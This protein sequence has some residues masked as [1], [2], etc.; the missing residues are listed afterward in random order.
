MFCI[1]IDVAQISRKLILNNEELKSLT[2]CRFKKI[3]ELIKL[4]QTV[5]RLANIFLRAGKTGFQATHGIR[6]SISYRF[7]RSET[8]R[9]CLSYH[10][11]SVLLKGH[12][13]RDKVVVIRD[14]A[15]SCSIG[16]NMPAKSL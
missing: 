2:R 6:A 9:I 10:I 14:A 11:K 4:K 7:P 8:K 16:S 5:N 12:Y 3:Q 15:K 1:G 13:H